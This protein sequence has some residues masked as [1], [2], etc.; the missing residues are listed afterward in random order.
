MTYADALI[1]RQHT[2]SFMPGF[3]T[4]QSR[5][6]SNLYRYTLILSL[7]PRFISRCIAVQNSHYAALETLELEVALIYFGATLPSAN[8]LK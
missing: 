3:S 8:L 4:L 1:R 7:M 6:D 2:L 5:L